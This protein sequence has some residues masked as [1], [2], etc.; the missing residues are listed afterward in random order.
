MINKTLHQSL[1]MQIKTMMRYYFI[2]TDVTIK[3][4]LTSVDQDMEELEP[5]HPASRSGKWKTVWQFLKNLSMEFPYNAPI[6]H[7][8]VYPREMKMCIHEGS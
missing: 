2:P 1:E 4:I 5:S 8:D 6:S 3:K 7:L